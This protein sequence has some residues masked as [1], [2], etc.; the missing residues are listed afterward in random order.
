MRYTGHDIDAVCTERINEVESYFCNARRFEDEINLSEFV[1]EVSDICFS[2]IDVS[3]AEF[4]E[5]RG[6]P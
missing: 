1:I 2:R 6:S 3:A 5:D 4:F